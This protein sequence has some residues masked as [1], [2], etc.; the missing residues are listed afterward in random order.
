MKNFYLT[1]LV[2]IFLF[3]TNYTFS[4]KKDNNKST[5]SKNHLTFSKPTNAWQVG[6]FGGTSILMGDVSPTIFYGNKP[7]FPGHNFGI[8]IS[9]SWSYLISTRLRYSTSVMFTNDAV[10]STFTQ[11]QYN[12]SIRNNDVG[13]KDLRP[14]QTIFHNSRTQGHD[15]NFDLVFTLGNINYHRRRSPMVFRIFPTAGMFM[16]QTFYDQLDENGVPYDYSSIENLN[17]LGSTS[18][19][20]VNNALANLRDGKYETRA[21]EHTV[22]DENKFLGYNPRFTFGLGV[23][24]A[25]RI[26]D[27]LSLDIETRQLLTND[28]LIDG[29]QWQEPGTNSGTYSRNRTL[30]YDSYNQTTLGLTFSIVTKKVGEPLCMQNPLWGADGFSDKPKTES[31]IEEM[32]SANALLNEKVEKLE[33]DLENMDLLVKLLATKTKENAKNDSLINSRPNETI[34]NELTEEQKRLEEEAKRL[35]EN[36]G[37]GSINDLDDNSFKL[38]NGDYMHIAD[39]KGDIKADYYLVTGSFRIKS[40]AKK[41]QKAW[42]EKGINT[43]LMTDFNSGLYRVVIDYSNSHEEALNMLD[44][45]RKRVLRTIWIIKSK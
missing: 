20:D 7:A 26:T 43:Y 1:I 33:K 34:P 5:S 42:S 39:L 32:D 15:L 24:M 13:L 37:D 41:D 17:D 3:S 8:F 25:I 31:K 28:D 11:N 4:Q 35:R 38:R 44:D 23:G 9:K 12:A 19:K 6:I 21:E 30:N 2:V 14:G 22:Y 27:Y 40:N 29:M 18:R 36:S 16:Y 45:Y 10:A